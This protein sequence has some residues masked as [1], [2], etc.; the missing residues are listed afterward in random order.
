MTLN[1]WDWNGV[2]TDQQLLILR[3]LDLVCAYGVACRFLSTPWIFRRLWW[4]SFI[5]VISFGFDGLTE[6]LPSKCFCGIFSAISQIWSKS[7]NMTEYQNKEKVSLFLFAKSMLQQVALSP[8]IA[9]GSEQGNGVLCNINVS[10][11]YWCHTCLNRLAQQCVCNFLVS[12][13]SV[14][15]GFVTLV[16][17]KFHANSLM[18]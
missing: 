13:N 2:P 14:L 3:T 18:S 7:F 12:S 5:L 15:Q 4:Q 17:F 1:I 6:Q 8:L 10:L 11:M 16:N 9:T